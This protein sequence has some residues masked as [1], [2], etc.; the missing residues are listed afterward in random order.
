MDRIL[1]QYPESRPLLQSTAID[2]AKIR[3]RDPGKGAAKLKTIV[4]AMSAMR[5][6]K[7]AHAPRPGGTGQPE[8]R[9]LPR[10]RDCPEQIFHGSPQPL[11][12]HGPDRRANA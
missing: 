4:R 10:R 2:A 5:G 3:S 12:Q 7:V 11:P 6:L 9:Q 8:G 1:E